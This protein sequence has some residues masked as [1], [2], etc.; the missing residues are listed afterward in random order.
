M[1]KN[2]SISTA[3]TVSFVLRRPPSSISAP[4]AWAQVEI[5]VAVGDSRERRLLDHGA[6]AAPQWRVL[7][8]DHEANEC[9][10]VRRD[11]EVLHR[12]HVRARHSHR[13]AG[14]ELG[15]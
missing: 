3:V 2:W 11:A 1:L 9:F 14:H 6:G 4:S 15:R 5:Y 10:S 8:V 13:I 7:L 12:A